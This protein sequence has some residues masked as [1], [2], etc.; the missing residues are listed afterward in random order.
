LVFDRHDSLWPIGSTEGTRY[1]ITHQTGHGG[2]LRRLA[3]K[4]GYGDR[5]RRPAT[6]TG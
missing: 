2:R 5:P 4:T 3:T 1:V 6:E